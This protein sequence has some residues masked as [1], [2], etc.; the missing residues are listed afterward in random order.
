MCDFISSFLLLVFCECGGVFRGVFGFEAVRTVLSGF[1]GAVGAGEAYP[2]VHALSW[3]LTCSCARRQRSSAGYSAEC[4]L[5][6]APW[7]MGHMRLLRV[8]RSCCVVVLYSD[9]SFPP[10]T[11]TNKKFHQ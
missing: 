7:S 6:A 1:F 4:I 5:G 10:F 11:Y 2:C 8:D 3:A 9:P